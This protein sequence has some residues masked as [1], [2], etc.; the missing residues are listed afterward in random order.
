MRRIL[1][2][3]VSLWFITSAAHAQSL[4]NRDVVTKYCLT[5]HSDNAKTGGLSLEKLDVDHPTADAETWEKAI[6]KLRAGLMPPAGMP[7]PDRAA[8]DAFRSSLEKSIDVAAAQNPNPGATA[9]HRL[10]RAEYAN[11]IRDLIAIDV[12]PATILPAA[13]SEPR[14]GIWRIGQGRAARDEPQRGTGSAARSEARTLL[15][16]RS[17]PDIDHF[18]AARG[19]PSGKGGPANNRRYLYQENVRGC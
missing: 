12:D 16:H 2:V 6:R 5:C 18:D 10:N 3:F 9:L 1:C 14:T 15:L 7:R 13:E 4:S 11:A 8:V 17:R 19:S